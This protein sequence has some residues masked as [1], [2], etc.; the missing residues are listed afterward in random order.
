MTVDAARLERQLGIPVVP[1]QANRG[2]GLQ[3]LRDALARD[4]GWVAVAGLYTGAPVENLDD[5][6]TK[7]AV[8]EAVPFLPVLRHTESGMRKRA[9]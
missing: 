2:T 8:A 7:L 1:I 9:E 3:Q 5:L 4:A 6:V